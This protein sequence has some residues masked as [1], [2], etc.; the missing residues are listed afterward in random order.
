MNTALNRTNNIIIL[1]AVDGV[2]YKRCRS[3][4][5]DKITDYSLSTHLNAEVM[6]FEKQAAN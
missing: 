5:R 1:I 2:L 4:E 3:I 6:K